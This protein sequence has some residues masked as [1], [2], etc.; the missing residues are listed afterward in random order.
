MKTK[1]LLA[2]LALTFAPAMAFAEGC[3]WGHAKEEVAMSCAA[4]SVYDAEA[5]K[6]VPTTG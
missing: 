5:E 4:G 2:A 3:Q 1:T 6:C